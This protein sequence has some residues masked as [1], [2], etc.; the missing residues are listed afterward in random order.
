[1]DLGRILDRLVEPQ[2]ANGAAEPSILGLSLSAKPNQVVDDSISAIR[3][4]VESSQNP[5]D[6]K[7]GYPITLIARI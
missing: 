7:T 4:R 1:M 5:V 2:L 3:H 6:I